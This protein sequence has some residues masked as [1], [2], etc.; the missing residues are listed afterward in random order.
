M[1]VAP[2]V[3]KYVQE[4]D[5]VPGWF[6]PLDARLFG[7]IDGLQKARGT[8]G[9][10]L[11]IG[12]YLGKSAILLGYLT[13]EDED[14]TV[15]DPFEEM[16]EVGDENAAENARHYPGL[17]RTQFE[18]QYL[19]F[20]SSLPTVWEMPSTRIDRE[21]LAGSYRL[22]HVD[23]SHAYDVVREDIATARTLLG[24]GGV[25]VIDDWPQPHTPGVALAA[26]EAF[27][28]GEMTLLCLSNYK[29]YATWDPTSTLREDLDAWAA[30]QPDVDV[31]DPHRLAG[32]IVRRYTLVESL[33]EAP[34]DPPVQA[35]PEPAPQPI[36]PRSS[37]IRRV[38]RPFVPPIALDAYRR[39]RLRRGRRP[40]R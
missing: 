20:H 40:R 10:I 22:V 11:E 15:C 24:P 5:S 26:W 16:V 25:V 1:D 3:A 31:T 32:R 21:T 36:V 18:R 12:A 19:R 33:P 39:L 17:H 29:L 27:L 7:A 30:S 34:V 13:E 35:I 37:T 14:L 4:M 6:Y 23:G 2:E 8:R 28:R 38:V 9:H